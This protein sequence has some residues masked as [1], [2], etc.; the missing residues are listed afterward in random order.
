VPSTAITYL[1]AVWRWSTRLGG[2]SH[3]PPPAANWCAPSEAG[4]DERP[5]SLRWTFPNGRD[6]YPDWTARGHRQTGPK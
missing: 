1:V 2:P 4:E 6:E 3:L 5:A